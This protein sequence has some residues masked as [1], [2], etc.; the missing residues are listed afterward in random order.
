MSLKWID[1]KIWLCRVAS[2]TER[3]EE[4]VIIKISVSAIEANWKSCQVKILS[5]S[6]RIF[7]LNAEWMSQRQKLII[8]ILSV[9][10]LDIL[11]GE[12]RLFINSSC[13]KERTWLQRIFWMFKFIF[14]NHKSNIFEI[15]PKLSCQHLSDFFLSSLCFIGVLTSTAF[16]SVYIFQYCVSL[17]AV[18]FLAACISHRSFLLLMAYHSMHGLTN[19][20][21]DS[22]GKMLKW[23]RF[24]FATTDGW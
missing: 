7:T 8:H 6:N 22:T 16:Y 4:H 5:L 13:M 20:L 10:F 12:C 3:H 2:D 9:R 1:F 15:S 19:L 14:R 23:I 18:V 24:V 11:D 17:F 21:I